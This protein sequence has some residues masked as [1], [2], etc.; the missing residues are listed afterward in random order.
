MAGGRR[1]IGWKLD[2]EERDAL[3]DRFAAKCPDVVADHVTLESGS[4]APLPPEVKAAIVGEAGDDSLQAMVVA[5][6]GRT[7]RPDGSRYHITWSLDRARGRKPVHSNDVIRQRGWSSLE[8]QVP[9]TLI[10]AEF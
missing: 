7:E 10:P 9:V 8:E 3:L 5:I 4:D 1:T 6:D 2:R